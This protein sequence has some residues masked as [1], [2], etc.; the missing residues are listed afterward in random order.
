MSE[1][2]TGD[3]IMMMMRITFGLIMAL[4]FFG[5][6]YG[7]IIGFILGNGAKKVSPGARVIYKEYWGGGKYKGAFRGYYFMPKLI[8]GCRVTFE[9]ENNKTVTLFVSE[10]FYDSVSIGSTG[11]LEYTGKDFEAFT[12][13]GD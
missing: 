6:F 7:R 8:A 1:N 9:L 2:E 10:K 3:L 13:S 11:T 5:M 4:I 12:L